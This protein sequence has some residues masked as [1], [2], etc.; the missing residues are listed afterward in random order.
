[1]K[2]KSKKSKSKLTKKNKSNK[3][4]NIKLS[5]ENQNEKNIEEEIINTEIPKKK[6]KNRKEGKCKGNKNKNEKEEKNKMNEEDLDLVDSVVINPSQLSSLPK[7]TR[8]F[9][10]SEI[11]EDN[12][13]QEKEEFKIAKFFSQT[14]LLEP[15][16]TNKDILFLPEEDSILSLCDGKLYSLNI[17]TYKIISTYFSPKNNIISFEYNNKLRQI[18]TLLESSMIMIFDFDTEKIISQIK[19]HKAMGKIVKID[20]SKTFF[21]VV[22]SR[23]NIHIYNIKNLSLE[24]TLEDHTHIIY[25]IIFNPNKEK[26]ELYSCS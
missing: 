18:I 9:E 19:I 3:N 14:K 22:T 20:P 13:K 7:L 15:K 17:T 12:K 25:D 6:N 24:C 16:N 4:D 11:Y 1:M 8:V 26:F 10:E 5:E 23:N 21:A 2:N